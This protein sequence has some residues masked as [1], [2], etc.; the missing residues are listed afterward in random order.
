M[1]LSGDPPHTDYVEVPGAYFF[2]SLS[3]ALNEP[4]WPEN[5]CARGAGQEEGGVVLQHMLKMKTLMLCMYV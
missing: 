3:E 2:G 5:V 4:P 1:C